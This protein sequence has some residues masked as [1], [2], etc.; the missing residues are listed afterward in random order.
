MKNQTLSVP[1]PQPQIWL[2]LSR[3]LKRGFV[4]LAVALL[5]FVPQKVRAQQAQTGTV[6][7]RVYDAAGD[8][9]LYNASVKVEGTL[10]E[11]LTDESGTFRLRNVPAGKAQIQA[12]YPGLA[13]SSTGVVVTSGGTANLEINLA[14][15]SPDASG[16]VLELEKFSVVEQRE[17]SARNMAVNEQRNAANIKNVVAFDEY[18]Y[19]S[20]GNLGEFLKHIPGVSVDY[21]ASIP[22]GVSV[23]GMPS[24]T[25]NIMSDGMMLAGGETT[26]A[27]RGTSLSMVGTDNISRIE[28]TKVPTPDQP[29]SGIGGT[30][31]IISNSA[32]NRRKPLLTFNVYSTFRGDYPWELRG[33]DIGM[34][35][36]ILGDTQTAGHILPS[37]NFSYLKPVNDRLA[38]SVSGS[39]ILRFIHNDTSIATW[40]STTYLQTTS[41]Y[42]AVPQVS[43]IR[44][45]QIKADYKLGANSLISASYQAR[46]RA[47]S[48]AVAD[49]FVSTYGTGV[50][51]GPDF[52]SG[53]GGG[54]LQQ[55]NGFIERDNSNET[56]SL[57]YEYR[58]RDYKFDAG[59]SFSS[60]LVQNYDNDGYTG[61]AVAN[62][63]GV[64][65]RG[66][67]IAPDPDK[68]G[69][70]VPARLTVTSAGTPIDWGNGNLYSLASITNTDLSFRN[71]R[72]GLSANLQR[73]FGTSGLTMLKF[74]FLLSEER[75]RSDWN[76]KGYNFRSGASA[77]VRQASAYGIVDP[78]MFSYL[79]PIA[80]SRIQRISPTLVY[81]LV[82]AHPEY[83]TE[84]PTNT[85]N[86]INNTYRVKESVS[87]VYLRADFRLL[88]N[89]LN[90]VTGARYEHTSDTTKGPLRN[91]LLGLVSEGDYG[92]LYPSLNASY[93]LSDRF[94]MRLAFARTIAR[95]DMQYIMPRA[96]VATTDDANGNRP[97]TVVET[98]LKPWTA[99][100]YDLSLETYL[101]KDSYGSVS[102][103]Q[104][105]IADFFG[106]STRAATLAEVTLYGGD[107]ALTNYV[108]VNRVNAGEA[109]IRGVELGYR[110]ALT[111]LPDWA[112]G[113]QVFVNYTHLQLEGTA[114]A[115]F[116]GFNPDTLS[117][118]FNFVRP[119][120]SLKFNMS[121]LG[122]TRR[123]S[124][125]TTGDYFWAGEKNRDTI[126]M[127]YSLTKRFSLYGQVADL[128]GG[129]YVDVQKQYNPNKNV[130]DYAR[131]QRL[132]GTGT[133][134]TL[135]IKGRF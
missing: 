87:A 49:V 86:K 44:S 126:S 62:L 108:I 92:S 19:T 73:D 32:L 68:L 120:F 127:E 36:P 104:K 40:N 12:R 107:P 132:I 112:R 79:P 66:D 103:F 90:V 7:G 60:T 34:P 109:R 2:S 39:Q 114:L 82:Q 74:G 42:R 57:K 124:T 18:G 133:E 64:A 9:Y 5:V 99:S 88:E 27:T 100:N 134:V 89:R 16:K 70:N 72:Q 14:N 37:F 67:G 59:Y 115:D 97:I 50:T 98:G 83:F 11:A 21:S 93:R 52:V 23:R 105:D 123:A 46:E 1:V 43:S 125:G 6:V 65:I 35:I 69:S 102:I 129:G 15:L 51:G 94:T 25:T 78:A 47:A 22:V 8:R 77:A 130:P 61:T 54:T 56:A 24:N 28:V 4:A 20:D 113:F 95:P 13:A 30:V 55:A 135:G 122:E 10:I 48:Q 58:G 101:S 96:A 76:T 81:Q 85:Q 53:T 75:Q 38:I 119:R 106:E 41:R 26:S 110:H 121:Y 117:Y 128:I 111:F 33:R 71:T 3:L 29:A 45:G 80:G 131:Y 17:M 84:Q 91:Q 31:N 118:G 63:A 116:S